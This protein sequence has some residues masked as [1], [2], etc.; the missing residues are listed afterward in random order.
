VLVHEGV[1]RL[2]GDEQQHFVERTVGVDVH[3]ARQLAHAGPYVSHESQRVLVALAVGG[4]LEVAQVVVDRELDVHVQDPAPGQQEREIG[5]GARRRGRLLAVADALDQARGPQHV[6]GHA[7]TPLPPRP[8]VGQCLTQGLGGVGQA[9]ADRRHLGQA[10]LHPA[11]LL[12]PLAL[13]RAHQV[14]HPGQLGPD[15]AHARLDRGVAHRQLIVHGPAQLAQA[16][17]DRGVAHRQLVVHGPAQL[18]Q[19]LLERGA[20]AG[21]LARAR[22]SLRAQPLARHLHHRVDRSVD[23]SPHR[24]LVRGRSSGAL[25]GGRRPHPADHREGGGHAGTEADDHAHDEQCSAHG[26]DV[27][28]AL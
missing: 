14:G 28:S 7:L 22:V 3:A 6:V 13:Q 10:G 15:V 11:V 1:H 16:R 19:A 21:Q 24:G 2:V 8:R 17:L 18:A 20:A 9:G 27:T 26:P 4:G 12:G 5:D 25:A 23:R